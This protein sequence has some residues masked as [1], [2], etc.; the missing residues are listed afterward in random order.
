MSVEPSAFLLKEQE[1]MKM[2]EVLNQKTK[3][4]LTRSEAKVNVKQPKEHSKKVQETKI[5]SNAAE[6][7]KPDLP[8]A[9]QKPDSIVQADMNVEPTKEFDHS[10]PPPKNLIPARLEKKNIS[11]E[12]LIKFLKSK[13]TILQDE[14]ETL[15][16]ENVKKTEEL[17]VFQEK[18]G[19]LE[20]QK[21]QLITKNNSLQASLKKHEDKVAEL[22]LQVRERDNQSAQLGKEGEN[23]KRDMKSLQQANTSL[24]R[25]LTKTQEELEALKVNLGNAYDREKEIRDRARL[26]KDGYEKQI[27]QLRKQRVNLIT[28]YKQQ[29]LLLDNLK[30]QNLCLEE[31]KMIDL[32]EKDFTKI[33]NWDK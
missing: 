9:E 26:E 7:T 10:K 2:N 17:Q 30:R 18:A 23:T 3:S 25:R 24:E 29:S 8:K 13:V 14:M 16:K 31:A 4:L 21:E 27:K 19:K 33:L 11:S 28:A 1:L 15:Q 32:S 6:E 22:E 5:K 12:G 20:Q